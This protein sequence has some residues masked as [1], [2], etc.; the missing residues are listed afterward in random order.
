MGMK[1]V[2]K[3]LCQQAIYLIREW[4]EMCI[5]RIP[6]SCYHY[7]WQGK[8]A[9]PMISSI[10]CI[11]TNVAHPPW[12]ASRVPNVAYSR[13][14]RRRLVSYTSLGAAGVAAQAKSSPPGP[15]GTK[16][17]GVTGCE[18]TA[19]NSDKPLGWKPARVP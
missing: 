2:R 1:K 14:T 16:A 17:E 9:A 8:A 11:A 12:L 7:V 13:N 5:G 19:C 6:L 18:T 4:V 10:V 15:L 3:W